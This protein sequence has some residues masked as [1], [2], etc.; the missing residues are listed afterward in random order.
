MVSEITRINM[1]GP[2][3]ANCSGCGKFVPQEQV[4]YARHEGPPGVWGNAPWCRDCYMRVYRP[5]ASVVAELREYRRK[6]AIG[7]ATRK[8]LEGLKS[9]LKPNAATVYAYC[10]ND[11]V[12]VIASDLRAALRECG[13]EA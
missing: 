6:P 9:I 12:A 5:E 13:L 1:Q 8:V 3:E 11:G 2:F 4:I 7:D 10:G